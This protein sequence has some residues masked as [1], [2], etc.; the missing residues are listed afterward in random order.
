MC[1][2]KRP[3]HRIIMLGML[4]EKHP[5]KRQ[6]EA[7]SGS[8]R[9]LPRLLTQKMLVHTKLRWHRPTQFPLSKHRNRVESA[10]SHCQIFPQ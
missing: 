7:W 9:L 10:M 4:I 1:H 2:E 5:M 8:S 3:T 6:M